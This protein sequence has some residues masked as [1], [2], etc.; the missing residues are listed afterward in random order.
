[1]ALA[2]LAN[3]AAGATYHAITAALG[4][5]EATLADLNTGC[6]RLWEL[7][8]QLDYETY[9]EAMFGA[10]VEPRVRA[11]LANGLWLNHR[12][13]FTPAFVE[14]VRKAY[15]AE[16]AGAD[17][18]APETVEIVNR[19]VNERTS[20]AIPAIAEQFDSRT[21]LALV[22]AVSFKGGWASVFQPQDTIEAPFMLPDGSQ[23]PCD[24]MQQKVELVYAE[25]DVLQLVALPFNGTGSRIGPKGGACMV[26]VLPRP[27]R[28]PLE[29]LANLGDSWLERAIQLRARPVEVELALPR[30]RIAYVA[31]LDNTL[32]ALGMGV[33]FDPSQADFTRITPVRPAWL[34]EVRHS[35]TLLV[36][37]QGAEAAGGTLAV[38]KYIGLAPEPVSMRVDRP[39]LCAI[40]SA[41]EW[42]PLFVGLVS[43]PE[44]VS[45]SE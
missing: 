9:E 14:T 2:A 16:V 4:V 45:A 27:G 22:S 26:V 44:R 34:S 18:D 39:F 1:M 36:N 29:A 5:P 31:D 15:K 7:L 30:F 32:A 42:V 25:S 12:L 3:G 38:I 17:F 24:L 40:V 19:W 33:A 28:T 43:R 23:L 37:E 11:Q 6:A 10:L 8:A 41:R 35:A 20:G 13:P 21:V